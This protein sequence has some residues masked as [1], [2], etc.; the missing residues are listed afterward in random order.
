MTRDL[1][2]K[3]GKKVIRAGSQNEREVAHFELLVSEICKQLSL[4]S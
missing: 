2:E 1:R 4:S 3:G